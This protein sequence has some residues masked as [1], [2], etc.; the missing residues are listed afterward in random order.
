MHRL[1]RRSF[2][3]TSGLGAG[4]MTMGATALAGPASALDGLLSGRTAELAAEPLRLARVWVTRETAHLLGDFDDTHNVF[5]DGSVEVLLWPGDLGRLVQA[6]LRHEVTVADL[7]A[8]DAALE[9][10]SAGRPAGLRLQPGETEDG[11]YRNLAQFNADMQMLATDHPDICE[12]IELPFPSLQGRTVY[13]LEI[14]EDVARKDGRPVYYNDGVHHAR[15]WPAAEMPIMWA[16]DLIDSYRRATGTGTPYDPTPDA[17]DE[18]MANIVRHSRN[19]IIPVVNPDGYD[20]SRT[21]PAGTGRDVVDTQFTALVPGLSMQ[22]WRKN[23]RGI[24]AGFGSFNPG[25][26][27]AIPNNGVVPTTPG[28]IGVDCNRNYAYRW[29][30]NGSSAAQYNE[31]YR[32]AEPFSEPESRNVQW[33]HQRWQCVS[34]ITHHTSGDLVLWAW[35]DTHEDAPDDNLLARVGFASARYNGYRPTKSIDLYVTTGTCSDYTYGSFGSVSYTFEH[36]GS[37]FHPP[38]EEVVPVFYANN[39]EALMLMCELVCLE[40][41]QRGHL[42]AAVAADAEVHKYLVGDFEETHSGTLYEYR[43][44]PLDLEGRH[45]CVITGQLIDADRKGVKGT[46]TNVKTYANPLTPGNPIGEMEWPEL[47]NA[48]IETDD[49]G[50]F[51]WIVYP[52]TLPAME[53]EGDEQTI[54]L[55]CEA[56]GAI[57]EVPGI[58]LSRGDVE[59]VGT[60]TVETA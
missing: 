22:Y 58:F 48:T 14:A 5:E 33:V 23:M 12:L 1:S 60:I 49:D 25:V 27:S 41:E 9:A 29:G 52:T 42:L 32:G 4:A 46:V 20:Y 54:T 8:R 3:R 45:H 37:S 36:A 44:S 34:G 28:A 57:T 39:R 59:D 47:W 53:Y 7:V 50:Y 2:L 15:E 19:I 31:T 30:G 6:G 11:A 26:E 18:R 24:D 13:G 10:S 51:R 35:G 40:P 21:G 55:Q 16:F 43:N 17:H 38:Y 56:G